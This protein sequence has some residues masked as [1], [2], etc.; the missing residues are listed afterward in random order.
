[1]G[2]ARPFEIEKHMLKRCGDR[3]PLEANPR[4]APAELGDFGRVWVGQTRYVMP[5]YL[6]FAR[7]FRPD[8]IVADPFEYSALMVGAVLGVP[9]VHHRWGVD[10]ISGPAR[11]AVREPLAELCAAHGLAGLPDPDV[12]LDPCP[13][14]LQLP[15]IERGTP[16]RAVPFNGPGVLPS[17]RHRS[18]SRPLRLVVSMGMRTLLLNGVAHVRRILAA[19]DDLPGTEVLATVEEPYR[20]ALGPLPANV[21]LVDPTPLDLFLDSC[22]AMVHHGGAG[23]TM[24]A[25]AFG[26]PQ[27]VLPQLADQFGHADRIQATGAGIALDTVELQDDPA[28]LREAIGD[29]FFDQRY[30]RSAADLAAEMRAMPS[31]VKVA[32]DLAVLAERART[33]VPA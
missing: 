5:Q 3:R 16:I 19:C 2:I 31:P 30:G 12:L 28:A 10:E 13:P 14:T 32:A 4:P 22:D 25:T 29:L 23:S 33:A 6:D 11:E 26:L 1:V 15:G 9:A 20:D 8:L 24:T 17:F 7:E 18:R 21:R 27:L